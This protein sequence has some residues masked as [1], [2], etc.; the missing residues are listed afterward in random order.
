[1]IKIVRLKTFSAKALAEVN[2]LLTQMG[3]TKIPPR[4]LTPRVFKKLLFQSNVYLLAARSVSSSDQKLVGMLTL[5]FVRVPSGLY[6]ILED[7]VVDRPYRK[8][9]VGRLLMQESIRLA[10]SQKAR[11]IGLRTNPKRLEANKL[12]LQLGFFKIGTNFYRI[13][14]F[15]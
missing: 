11:H 15:K 5:Y 12:Y 9:G 8:W 4:A 3:L 13:N 14:L 2:R 1:M 10:R 6:A 7:L